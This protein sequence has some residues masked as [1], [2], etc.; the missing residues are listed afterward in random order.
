MPNRE[1]E[2]AGIFKNV[3]EELSMSIAKETIASMTFFGTHDEE[4]I[5]V[6]IARVFDPSMGSLFQRWVKF[7]NL[8]LAKQRKPRSHA[9]KVSSIDGLLDVLTDDHGRCKDPAIF[10][11]YNPTPYQQT[12]YPT[13]KEKRTA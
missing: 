3:E 1:Y 13:R 8:M 5:I 9:A 2:I 12:R 7:L 6:E 4:R 10:Q 11:H